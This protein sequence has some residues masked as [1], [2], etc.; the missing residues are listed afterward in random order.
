MGK[1]FE[2]ID[3]ALAAWL[4]RQPVFFVASAPLDADGHVNCSPKGGDSLRVLGPRE[5]AYLDGSGSGIETV[6][7]LRENG[8]LV[9]MCCA[10]DGAPRIVRLH[11]RGEVVVP[12]AA[13]FDAL[14]TRFEPLA[15]PTVRAIVR[16]EV[17]RVADSC[18]YGVPLMDFRAPRRDGAAWLAK[19]SDQTLRR[20]L[21]ANNQRSLDG[22]P[23]MSADEL[24]GVVIRRDR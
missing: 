22:L 14:L 16:L 12:G 18:G 4:E 19:S 9:I 8:R 5:V 21:V 24:E 10:F 2:T 13:G 15:L 23:A 20:Y 17:A 1:T 11:G 6:A 7:H 3:P